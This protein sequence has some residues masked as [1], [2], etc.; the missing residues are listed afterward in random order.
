MSDKWIARRGSQGDAWMWEGSA[1][2]NE[3]DSPAQE[4]PEKSLFAA[5]S[6]RRS[7][8][9]PLPRPALPR[10][11][12][13]WPAFA[14]P[15]P[16]PALRGVTNRIQATLKRSSEASQA[17][18]DR[19]GGDLTR[20]AA[21]LAVFSLIAAVALVAVVVAS[22]VNNSDEESPSGPFDSPTPTEA[23]ESAT[24]TR[25]PSETP[26]PTVS[27]T[28][29]A[30]LPPEPAGEVSLGF[31]A[32]EPGGWWFGD[33]PAGAA[34]YHPG[35]EAPFLLRW[36]AEPGRE[37]VIEIAYE[38]V[39]DGVP[40]IDRLTGVE[41]AGEDIFL[42]QWGPGTTFPDAA[43]PVPVPVDFDAAE[44][45]P[46]LL[47]LY[48]GDFTLLPTGPNPAGPCEGERTISV[49]ARA[50]GGLMVLMGSAWL[51]HPDDHGGAS[52]A[53]A[54]DTITLRASVEGVGAVTIGLETG[55]VTP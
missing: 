35:D 34:S 52:A 30:L 23:G 11:R 39:S 14:L 13:A 15:S 45:T 9:P 32:N 55:V 50:T 2:A 25:R 51:A 6:Q 49:P 3:A 19:S 18:S 20:F 4:Q 1:P 10:V 24:A 47:Y 46:G 53:D 21:V 40:A 17:E 44:L 26:A 38:C 16:F 43:V 28:P 37:Y 42:A 8:S 22:V 48:G 27:E 12:F 54:G 36:T 29:G 41:Y 31:W 7:L 33:L 5:E